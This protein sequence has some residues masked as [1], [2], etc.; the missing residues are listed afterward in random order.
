MCARPAHPELRADIVKA[1]TGIVED[2]GPDC[3]TMRQVAEKVGYSATTLYLYFKDKDAILGE[4]MAAGFDDLADFCAMSEVGPLAV[5]KFRQRGRA[6]VVWGLMHQSLY[7]LMFETRVVGDPTPE[8]L[9]RISRAGVDS[10]RALDEAI[11]AG[12]IRGVVDPTEFGVALWAATHGVTSLAISRR[13][14]AEAAQAKP[15]ELLAEAARLVDTLV[16]GMLASHVS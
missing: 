5:D 15:A 13:I 1:A 6:Y 3:V 7:Q 10:W 9:V 16:D 14:S 8:Q 4:V 2:C 11:A 12:D